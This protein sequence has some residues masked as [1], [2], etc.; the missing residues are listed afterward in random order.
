MAEKI[1][2]SPENLLDDDVLSELMRLGMIVLV[3]EANQTVDS[4]VFLNFLH[5]REEFK[6][7]KI[8]IGVMY[9]PKETVVSISKDSK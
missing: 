9:K 6:T 3:L 1:N 8:K 4:R 7:E 5:E 2:I